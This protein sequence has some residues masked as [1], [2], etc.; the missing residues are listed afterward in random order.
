MKP[1]NASERRRS[2]GI[3]LLFF[4]STLLVVIIVVIPGFHIPA[5]QNKSLRNQLTAYEK[6]KNYDISFS[7]LLA[8]VNNYEGTAQISDVNDAR[9]KQGILA[10]QTYADN[11]S[12]EVKGFYADVVHIITEMQNNDQQTR[13]GAGKNVVLQ[14]L[15]AQSNQLD[16]D[17]A[18]AQQQ[19]AKQSAA[20]AKTQAVVP[21]PVTVP[22]QQPASAPPAKETDNSSRIQAM[23][24][25]VIKFKQPALDRF[26]I[27][28]CYGPNTPVVVNNQ[29][30]HTFKE[31]YN[32]FKKHKKSSMLSLK[33]ETENNCVKV[34][35][36][37]WKN[38]A[39]LG[40]NKLF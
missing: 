18:K 24:D 15:L 35:T 14:S 20:A 31:L 29:T 40:T 17:L 32:E 19:A 11:D 27:Y 38:N 2:F 5:M 4:I 12:I 9:I 34:I 16:K 37:E 10:L 3:F 13:I 6:G 8:S 22:Q 28:L 33:I 36:I 26:N 30:G 21:Q 39:F 23:L 25:S 7:D 1:L